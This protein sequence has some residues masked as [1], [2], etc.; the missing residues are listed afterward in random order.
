MS[1]FQILEESYSKNEYR[2]NI[3]I[4]YNDVK[5]KK[6]LSKK[7]ISFS[8]PEN[9]SVIFYPALFINEEIQNFNENYFY[10]HWT[11]VVIKN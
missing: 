10:T 5:V 1:S 9:I 11:K 7:N 4:L 8:L 2:A 6:F 3:K